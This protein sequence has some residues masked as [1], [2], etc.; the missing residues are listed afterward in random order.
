M[1]TETFLGFT[2]AEQIF[3]A[4]AMSISLFAHF[5]ELA[6]ICT[7]YPWETFVNSIEHSCG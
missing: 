6:A 2:E 5:L 4:P 3:K 7:R 1:A